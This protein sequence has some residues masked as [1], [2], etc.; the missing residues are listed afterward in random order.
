MRLAVFAVLSFAVSAPAAD[1]MLDP[2]LHHLRVGMVREWANF[3]AEAEGPTL[4]VRFRAAPNAREHALRLRQ[5]DVKQPWRV[6]LNDKELGRLLQ[7]ENDTILYLP[8]PPGR[9]IDGDNVLRI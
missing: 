2:K 5:Q 8:I 3:P 1:S 6:L 9:L 7:D 4:T